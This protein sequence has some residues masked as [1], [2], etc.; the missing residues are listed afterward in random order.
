MK[1]D[2]FMAVFKFQ[3][4]FV[5]LALFAFCA[6]A[7]VSLIAYS[8]DD[9]LNEQNISKPRIFIE[10]NGTEPVSDFSFFYYFTADNNRRPVLE[11]YYT[12]DESVSLVYFGHNKY[13]V[14]YDCYGVTIYPGEVFPDPNGNVVGIHYENWEPMRKDNDPSF[15]FSN[16]FQPNR[17]I[18]V[19][20]SRH[21]NVREKRSDSR[22]EKHIERSRNGNK[23]TVKVDIEVRR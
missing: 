19:Q 12:P 15:N 16:D 11:K 2:F 23:A 21:G 1:G 3:R 6:S 20:F 17:N 18:A 14:R 22:S 9:G 8:K 13:A 4:I 10:N 7:E 5:I